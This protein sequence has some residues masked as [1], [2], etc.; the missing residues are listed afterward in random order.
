[1][2][3]SPVALVTGG[4]RGIGAAVSA[5]LAEAGA[6]VAIN[7]RSDRSAAERTLDGINGFGS[8]WQADVTDREA[9]AAMIDGI[10]EVHGGIDIAVINAGVWRGGRIDEI[11]PDDWRT[12][13]A[14]ALDGAFHVSRAVVPVMRAAGRGRIVVVSSVVGMIGFPGDGAYATSKAGL[15]GLVR[16]LAKELARD[17]ITVNAV[18]PGFVETDM[19]AEVSDKGRE[20]M[21]SGTLLGRAGKPEDVAAAVCFLALEADYT[22]GHTLVVDGG[23]F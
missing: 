1:M 22:T 20:L 14:T 21:I 17:G 11:D 3:E 2:N 19:T 10:V 9:T 15:Y 5:L 6:T 13:L 12:V 7:F 23:M 16:S 4:S 8:L 18:A